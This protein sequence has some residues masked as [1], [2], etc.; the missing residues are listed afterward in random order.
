MNHQHLIFYTQKKIHNKKLDEIV[1]LYNKKYFFKKIKIKIELKK[2][3][4]KLKKFLM[5]DIFLKI[6]KLEN[7]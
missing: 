3:K 5:E 1:I 6:Q 7:F 4:L 2:K